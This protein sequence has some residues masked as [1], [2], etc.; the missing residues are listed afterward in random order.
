MQRA[1]L[2]TVIWKIWRK[3]GSACDIG[4]WI[5]LKLVNNRSRMLLLVRKN[6]HFGVFKLNSKLAAKQMRAGT[7]KRK[8]PVGL[9]KLRTNI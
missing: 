3:Q 9:D 7:W 6:C 8:G 2:E 1:L 4:V 5:E